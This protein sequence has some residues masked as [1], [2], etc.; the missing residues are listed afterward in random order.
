MQDSTSSLKMMKPGFSGLSE[1]S[2][3]GNSNRNGCVLFYNSLSGKTY[4]VGASRHR[5]TSS[6][7]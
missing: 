4:V 2:L 3:I 6:N 7:S 5:F 1:I